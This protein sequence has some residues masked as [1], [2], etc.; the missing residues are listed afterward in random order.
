M[1][2]FFNT[3]IVFVC[4]TLILSNHA[5][6]STN[7]DPQQEFGM[8]CAILH[9]KMQNLQERMEIALMLCIDHSSQCDITL[10]QS[11][12]MS[13]Q[14]KY[15]VASLTDRDS[16]AANFESNCAKSWGYCKR[17]LSCKTDALVWEPN[18]STA[19]QLRKMM[20][21][22]Q[23]STPIQFGCQCQQI[24]PQL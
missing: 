16:N 3:C 18:G 9:F 11:K 1:T 21:S 6:Q 8:R 2:W 22:L 12:E 17:Q 14:T 10:P 20:K 4:L 5:N 24:S 19:N 7:T 23:T 13:M 15:N